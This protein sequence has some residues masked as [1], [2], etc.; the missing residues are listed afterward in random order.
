MTPLGM[1]EVIDALLSQSFA[2]LLREDAPDE[3]FFLQL[4]ILTAGH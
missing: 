3:N 4:V 2:F 1:R